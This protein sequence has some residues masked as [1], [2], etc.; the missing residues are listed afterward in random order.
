MGCLVSGDLKEREEVLISLVMIVQAESNSWS[1]L[2]TS[3]FTLILR[4]FRDIPL[5]ELC[6]QSG[7]ERPRQTCHTDEEGNHKVIKW[8][9]FFL[10]STSESAAG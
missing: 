9:P 1:E 10:R 2:L 8:V 5:P 6:E 3:L 7:T 4:P